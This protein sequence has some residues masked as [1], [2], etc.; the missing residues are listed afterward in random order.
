MDWTGIKDFAPRLGIAYRLNEKTVLRSGFGISY[1]PFP[2]NTYAYN[3]PVKQNNAYSGNCSFCPA[4]LPN[5][6]V[7]KLETGFPAP[8]IVNIP[9]NGILPNADIN[10]V[11][12]VVNKHFREPYI[13]S[14]NAAIQRSLPFNFALDVAY[15]ANHGVDQPANA[16]LNA[17]TAV[18]GDVAS[19]PL[20]ALYKRKAD[21]N[22]RYVGHSSSYNSLQVK[23]DKRFSGGLAMTTAFTWSHALG[24]QSEDSGLTFYIN[25]PRN[26]RTLDFNRKYNFVQSYVYE[27]PFGKGKKYLAS[28]PLGYVVGGWQLNGI[29]TIASGT[30]LN[31]GGDSSGL[32]AP[33]NGNTLNHFG[34]IQTLKGN[35]R[36]AAW[37]DAT[38]CGAGVTTGC[39]AQPDSLQ[40][41]NLSPNVINGPGYWNLDGSVFRN[42]KIGER[43]TLEVRGEAFSAVNTPQWNNPDTT[44]G[45]S[46]FGVIRGAGGNRQIQLG[47]KITF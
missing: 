10:Q 5:G 27:L 24:Y 38:K 7:A 39:F 18:G 37:F 44:F 8:S 33:G 9:S 19:Q 20:F 13:E 47:T 23:L 36:D 17:S 11:Y 31:F 43:F 1:S 29:L 16:N 34:P 40:F 12:E 22:L 32:K 30:P 46:T 15:V 3:F 14:W 41:G 4:V 45:N 42:F 35:G 2:D 28:G 6:Q 25:G 21:T 26:W